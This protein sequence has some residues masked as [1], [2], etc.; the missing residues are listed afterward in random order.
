VVLS[1][2]VVFTIVSVFVV[3]FAALTVDTVVQQGFGP[4][5]VIAL[6]VL[7]L[8][9]VGGLGALRRPPHE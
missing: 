1:R 5:T 2:A 3:A 9:A 4:A 7:T 8:L 6:V